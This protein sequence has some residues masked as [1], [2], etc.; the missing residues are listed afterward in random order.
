LKQGD[1]LCS[2][3]P[4]DS[5][6]HLLGKRLPDRLVPRYGKSV[7]LRVIPG[8]QE[9][10]FPATALATLTSSSYTVSPESNRMGYRLSG[11]KIVRE[12]PERFISDCTTMGALQIPSDGQPIL[13]MADRQTT[14]GYPKIG[15]VITADLSLAAQLVPGNTITFS[16]TTVAKAQTALRK[17]RALLDGVLPPRKN[18][19]TF[20]ATH[21]S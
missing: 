1:I 12:G 19:D 7:T 9:N 14:G 3:Q 10:L 5:I 6:G 18:S 20:R 13:L 17:Q 2:R 4:I 8:Q 16:L 21:T 11:P 15:T